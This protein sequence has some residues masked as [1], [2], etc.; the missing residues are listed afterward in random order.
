MNAQARIVFIACFELRFVIVDK[1]DGLV[2]ADDFDAVLTGVFRDA[3]KVTI[4]LR[5]DKVGGLT[6]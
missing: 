3:R 4:W 1:T 5:M 6:V 2:V